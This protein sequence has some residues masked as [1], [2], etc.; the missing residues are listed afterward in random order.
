MK[1]R[2]CIQQR[3]AREQ[4]GAG[5]RRTSTTARPLTVAALL[6]PT[7]LFAEPRIR[8]TEPAGLSR[9][10]EPVR[11][12]IENRQEYVFVTIGAN[13]TKEL[14]LAELRPSDPLRVEYTG[15]SGFTLENAVLRADHSARATN[16]QVEDSGTLKGLTHKPFDVTLLRTRNRMH[17]APSFQREGES[18]Y[19]SMATWPRPQRTQRRLGAGWF[20]HQ[21]EGHHPLYPEV[22]LWAEYR[23]FAHVPYFFFEA[24]TSIVQPIQMYWLRGQEMTLDSFFTHVV[25]PQDGEPAMYE[26]EARKPVLEQDPL[27]VDVPW[28][29][30]VN[31]ERGYG[32][33]AVTLGY[34]ATTTAGAHTVINDGANDGKYWDR[35]LISKQ[36]TPLEPGDRYEERTAYV[37]FRASREAPVGEFLDW[38]KRLRHPLDAEVIRD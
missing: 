12:E 36:T 10:N 38:E 32:F 28:V 30:F 8:V 17:W 22:E 14:P 11:V 35:H 16:G 26:F 23:Y 9:T 37:L 18:G 19:T 7:L 1:L 24:V 20:V 34:R 29:A 27:P 33:G 15:P 6:L 13:E 21:R 31:L 2:A 3:R 25:F 5:L 4:A